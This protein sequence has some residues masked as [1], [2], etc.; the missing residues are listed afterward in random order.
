VPAI[1]S[2]TI[3]TIVALIWAQGW[4]MVVSGGVRLGEPRVVETGERDVLR[5]ASPLR[6]ERLSGTDGEQVARRE[7]RIDVGRARESR[8]I[9]SAPPHG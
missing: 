7:H 4:R 6:S 2:S 8:A 5:N 1:A 9:A 3:S